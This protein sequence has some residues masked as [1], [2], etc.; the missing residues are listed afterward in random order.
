LSAGDEPGAGTELAFLRNLQRV[1][2]EGQFTASYKYALLIALADLS[3]E[4]P[5]APDG[6]L[7]VPL[8]G[9]AERFIE[10]YW[11]HTAPF[12]GAGVLAQ[13]TARQA[14]IIGAIAGLQ[15]KA[16]TL[17]DARRARAWPALV[18][19]V[20]RLLLEMPLWKLQTIGPGKL[21]FLYEERLV[22]DA[23]VLKPGVSR[24]FRDL[25]G[26]VQALIQVA[27]LRYI[28][29]L[30]RN[31]SLIGQGGDLTEFLFG[32]ERNA[33]A[34]LREQLLDLQQGAC[35][36]CQA[37]VRSQGEV[38]H[39]VPWARYPRDLGHNLVVAHGA[40][41]RDK[42]DLLADVPH[43]VHWHERN[44]R[45][46]QSLGSLFDVV[47]LL[48]DAETSGRVAEWR[49]ESV[50]RGGGLVWIE[51]GRTRVLDT[52]WRAVLRQPGLC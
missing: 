26:V 34:P 27:W 9:L 20:R 8:D 29:R 49:Y 31:Q 4:R 30:P 24:C 35:F 21:L 45:H 32:A 5:A 47:H 10:L 13:N 33:L 46:A 48:H 43:L 36:Y 37:P 28:Q 25:H 50:E 14:S 41:N 38:D 3:V 40:C 51:R 18:A 11:R 39:F 19:S 42:S 2:D 1:Q 22:D 44:V 16:A 12:R 23:I 52:S 17:A 7:A 15:Q 6:T